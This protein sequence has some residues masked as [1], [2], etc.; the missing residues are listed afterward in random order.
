MTTRSAAQLTRRGTTTCRG[1]ASEGLDSVLD[2]GSQPLANELPL[3]AGRDSG[4]FPLHLRFCPTCGLGQVGE[5]VLPERIFG[6]YPYL[7]SMSSSWLDHAREYARGQAALMGL[8]RENL[9]IE[10]AS[11]DGYLLRE[12]K[13]LGVRTLG[14]EPAR[15]V[16]KLA[17][18][19]GIE[20][21]GEFFGEELAERIRAERGAPRLVVANNVLAHVPDMD[22]F[23]KG[24]RALCDERTRISVE[25]PTLLN[26]M[27]LG[28]FDTIYHEHFS[29]LSAYAVSKIVSR[30]GLE[31]VDIERLPTHGGSYRYW[32]AMAG[33][34]APTPSVARAIDAE[35]EGGLLSREL[36]EQFER[37][38][39]AT[40]RGL[41]LWLADRQAGERRVVAYGAA[42]KGNTLLNAAGV[43]DAVIIAAVDASPEKQGRYLP[44]SGIPILSPDSLAGLQP[45][46]VLLLPW[47]LRD[48]VARF[49]GGAC[50]AATLWVAIPQ[51]EVVPT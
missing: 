50:P 42:A 20:T 45:D 8:D 22:D 39:R 40:I 46:D 30:H 38:S 24:L 17:R 13:A 6:D 15:N 16:A 2:L 35:I 47:N 37:Q 5:Y 28:Q 33:V 31:L 18:A 43:D 36:H 51:M 9:V 11:N 14:V 48:E 49:I 26:L 21:I 27:R 29:Y 19:E 23:V 12:F 41:Q 1:C 10:V 44:G 7:S 34:M 25:N 3:E 32:L 4:R